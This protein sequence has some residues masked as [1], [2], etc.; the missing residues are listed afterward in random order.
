MSPV[1]RRRHVF[2]QAS[3]LKPERPLAPTLAFLAALLLFDGQ[4]LAAGVFQNVLHPPDIA[5]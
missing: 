1:R 4:A 2:I 3:A 5:A